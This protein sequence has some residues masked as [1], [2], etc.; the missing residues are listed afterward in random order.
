MIFVSFPEM[1]IS[2]IFEYPDADL[3]TT[4]EDGKIFINSNESLKIN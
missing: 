1:A 3:E 2:W 4:K